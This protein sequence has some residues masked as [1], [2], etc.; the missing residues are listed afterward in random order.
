[1]KLTQHTQPDRPFTQSKTIGM[2]LVRKYPSARGITSRLSYLLLLFLLVLPAHPTLVYASD[3]SSDHEDSDHEDSDH[4]DDDHEDDD[5]EDDDH[6]DDDHED[7]D[8]EDDDHEDDDHE[9]DDHE[10]DDH[11][12]DDH[13][14]DDHEDDEHEDDDHE[15]DDHEDDDHED[16]DHE[17]DDHEDDDHEDDDH[18]DDDHE[19][20]DHEDDPDEDDPDEDDPDE[21]D[22]DGNTLIAP[23]MMIIFGNA[24]SMNREMDD[25]TY[26]SID[27]DGDGSNLD[28]RYRFDD[29][30]Y[31]DNPSAG[32]RGTFYY[33][34]LYANQPLSKLH[35]SKQ[36]FL[37]AL[38][39]NE[40]SQNINLGFAT[41]R[42]TFGLQVS[43]VDYLLNRTWP[44][45][46]PPG[47]KPADSA[48][49]RGDP[50]DPES[51]H[52]NYPAGNP[53]YTASTPEKN[54]FAQDYSH[55]SY[56]RWSRQWAN[57]RTSATNA[58]ACAYTNYG[59]SPRYGN[60]ANGGL[61][62]QYFETGRGFLDDG[63]TTFMDQA[64][65]DGGLPLRLRYQS[66]AIDQ[67]Y[68]GTECNGGNNNY[69]WAVK[70]STGART[71]AEAN[72]G[73][74]VIEHSLCTIS[75]NSQTNRFQ[76]VFTANRPFPNNYPGHG[77]GYSLRFDN[78]G[79]YQINENGRL[80]DRN[81]DDHSD[82]VGNINCT[83]PPYQR[84]SYTTTIGQ[85]S[86]LLPWGPLSG[87]AN[88][89]PAY[90]SLNASYYE[91][92]SSKTAHA[93]KGAL[94]GWSGETQYSL[95]PDGSETMTASYPSG[96]A[97]PCRS[98]RNLCPD[99]EDA[100][101]PDKLFRYVKTM[102]EDLPDNSRHMGVFLDLPAPEAG[103]IDQRQIL[104][105]YMGYQQMAHSG[106]E[107]DPEN[108]SI[109]LDHGITT[110]SHPWY[111][112]QSPIY[113]SL[114][115]AMAYFSAYKEDDPFDDC[116]RSN[117]IL[118]FYDGK[119]DARWDYDD[120][121]NKVY[122]KPE[123]MSAR[124]FNEL[125]VKVHVVIISDNAGDIAQANLIAQNGGTEAAL[126][127]NNLIAL[128]DALSEVFGTIKQD[129][130]LAPPAIPRVANAG[131]YLFEVLDK[132][133]PDHGQ[134]VAY[135]LGSDGLPQTDTPAWSV[136]D[137]THMTVELRKEKSLSTNADGEIVNFYSDL[138]DAAFDA[139]PRISATTIREYT[140]DPSYS[141]GTYL[142]GR[143]SDALLGIIGDSQPVLVQPPRDPALF[144]DSDYRDYMSTWQTRLPQVLFTSQDGFLYGLDAATGTMEWSWMPR[145]FVSDLKN[146]TLF[147][148]NDPFNGQFS[149]VDAKDSFG[150][151]ATY[152]IGSAA[153]GKL[154]YG[155][156]LSVSD[157][158]L[159]L[160][161]DSLVWEEEVTGKTPGNAAP[162]I[163]RG[164]DN[165]LT[166]LIYANETANGITL[167]IRNITDASNT[168]ISADFAAGQIASTPLV[169]KEKNGSTYIYTGTTDGQL[170]R[171]RW[172]NYSSASLGTLTADDNFT[173]NEI[174]LGAAE[175]IQYIGYSQ[176]QGSEFLRLQSLHRFTVLKRASSNDDWSRQWSTRTGGADNYL[177]T[178][179]S[180]NTI[181]HL[182]DDAEISG[183]ALIVL[184]AVLLPVYEIAQAGDVCSIGSG[185]L[186][187][188]DL[189]NGLF[190]NSRFTVRGL[191]L[192]DTDYED[193]EQTGSNNPRLLVGYG[194][195][196][197]PKFSVFN[198]QM[199]IYS[200][201]EDSAFQR[202]N[203]VSPAIGSRT[204]RELR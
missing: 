187:F 154:H 203:L 31:T 134:V 168:T 132:Y 54:T 198:G 37:T 122:A 137:G 158:Q 99:T 57:W 1:M 139:S 167:K 27:A 159:T 151:Y 131:D 7:D 190:P 25:Q 128:Q 110:S 145:Q 76:A 5:H 161:S 75:Y 9:D 118:L 163:W 199:T 186:Y 18:E 44:E 196:H 33:S 29:A 195:I 101:D 146:Y 15:D 117:H 153:N 142:G 201:T 74:S 69:P 191:P 115:S 188:F 204:W 185:Y 141:G 28:D 102:G 66:A 20:D 91:G 160:A 87:N 8:H 11:E 149:V 108:Q 105:G 113:Q 80:V 179:S 77:G 144:L 119:E 106:L 46:Y 92:T 50:A 22:P 58:P 62:N 64:D 67:Q 112:Y 42:Q 63:F 192:L 4:E 130:S 59:G 51:A 162:V 164:N 165:G 53:I 90:Y 36:A 194:K 70:T 152:V 16:D 193:A 41:F 6:E 49:Y 19:D 147:D 175:P 104:R 126:A 114:M 34:N 148:N 93:D 13:E 23:N 172:E 56:L 85:S 121:G 95:N 184:G 181:Q 32:D 174:E 127:V 26:P 30:G 3:H 24:W 135:A 183:Q 200:H 2:N 116:G 68:I 10:D 129:A 38:N 169:V 88:N 21:D 94:S 55:F 86:Q 72:H 43:T 136:D 100:D 170:H 73:E 150:S 107:Y 109:A 96:V 52:P 157:H 47:G 81:G 125:A 111:G 60:P 178:P 89:V 177:L 61:N 45:V 103:Y 176:Y 39:N 82:V 171:L 48:S 143:S 12:D 189:N 124:L 97:D 40:L 138:D 202:V 71:T 83:V 166:F 79:T 78:P 65:G 156:K 120:N 17:D 14:D 84:D 35:Q 133:N 123:E 197:S 182:P 173:A 140:M 98:D 180:T 155:L